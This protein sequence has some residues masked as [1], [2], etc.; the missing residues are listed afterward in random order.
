[1]RLPMVFWTWTLI[2]LLVGAVFQGS[3]VF[4]DATLTY[5]LGA[6]DKSLT[7][8]VRDGLVAVSGLGGKRAMA[9]HGGDPVALTLIDR[10]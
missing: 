4:A 8:S 6:D 3:M 9:L 2:V 1:M 7:L 5:R 10:D